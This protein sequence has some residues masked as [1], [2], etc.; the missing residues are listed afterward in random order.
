[1]VYGVSY[2]LV[3]KNIYSK[4]VYVCILYKADFI[5]CSS[6]SHPQGVSRESFSTR[7]EEVHNLAVVSITAVLGILSLCLTLKSVCKEHQ[8]LDFTQLKCLNDVKIVLA[9]IVSFAFICFPVSTHFAL[10]LSLSFS[11]F[12]RLFSSS[13]SP[14]PVK[15]PY[16]SV[17]IHYKSPSPAGYNQRRSQTMCQ[18]STSSC[19]LEFMPEEWEET[20]TPDCVFVPCVLTSSS[21]HCSCLFVLPLP[22]SPMS[23]LFLLLRQA[24]SCSMLCADAACDC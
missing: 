16:T 18:I 21:T 15:R 19:I 11:S 9:L 12:A 8:G 6:I 2:F 14:P 20:C 13:A 23:T 24:D 5:L 22:L 10:S 1:M 4:I 3:P 17:N 7:E